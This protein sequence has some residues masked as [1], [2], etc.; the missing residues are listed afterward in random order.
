MTEP[1][2]SADL[3][4]ICKHHS[5]S[6]LARWSTTDGTKVAREFNEISG[7]EWVGTRRPPQGDDISR[8]VIAGLGVDFEDGDEVHYLYKLRCQIQSCSYAPILREWS[9]QLLDEIVR[10][11]WLE[12][13]WLEPITDIDGLIRRVNE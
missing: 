12:S 7:M 11:N 10:L 4:I 6:T 13:R 5:G 9:A 2:P 8:T 3:I 1:P